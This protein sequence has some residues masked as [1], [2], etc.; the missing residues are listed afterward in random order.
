[1]IHG[2]DGT[3]GRSIVGAKLCARKRVKN[4][5]CRS[6]ESHKLSRKDGEEAVFSFI[7]VEKC[8]R[9]TYGYHDTGWIRTE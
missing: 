3:H 1:M 4:Y 6:R 9:V 8:A 2:C 7:W 5:R